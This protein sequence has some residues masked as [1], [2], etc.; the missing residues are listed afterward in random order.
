VGVSGRDDRPRSGRPGEVLEDPDVRID[1][2]LDDIDEGERSRRRPP[3]FISRADLTNP[4]ERRLPD[5]VG[6]EREAP[7]GGRGPVKF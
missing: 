2:V 1:E 6:K 7:G 4:L 3:F 5:G